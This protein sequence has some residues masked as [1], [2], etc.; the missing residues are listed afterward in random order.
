MKRRRRDNAPGCIG[1][2]IL[3]H[4]NKVPVAE[5]LPAL[6]SSG[7]LP[8]KV[9]YEE[10]EPVSKMSFPSHVIVVSHTI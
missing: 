5:V 4:R 3:K 7:V 6:V 1:R 9:D 2:L 10:N 8:L